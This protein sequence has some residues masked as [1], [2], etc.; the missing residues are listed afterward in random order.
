MPARLAV[1][2]IN[3]TKYTNSNSMGGI[4]KIYSEAQG[5]GLT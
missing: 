4:G 3:H 2:I 1:D 5:Q